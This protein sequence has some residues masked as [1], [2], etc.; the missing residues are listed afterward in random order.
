MPNHTANIL[1]VSG[2]DAGTLMRRHLRRARPSE[3][4]GEQES[5]PD[6]IDFQSIVP[7][8]ASLIETQSGSQTSNGLA[9]LRAR[10]SGDFTELDQMLS[11]PWVTAAGITTREGLLKHFEEKDPQAIEMGR[12]ALANI[13]EHGCPTWYEWAIKYW[14]TKWNAY[15]GSIHTERSP[16]WIALYFETAWSPP[17]P[18]LHVLAELYPDLRFLEICAD[19]GGGFIGAYA[20]FGFGE[21][22]EV[23][24]TSEWSSPT[25]NLILR[26]LGR[27][28]FRRRPKRSVKT[29]DC[30]AWQQIHMLD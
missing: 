21:T 19:E 1:I 26:K 5:E 13:K 29:P 3:D 6:C 20:V 7:M 24:E 12:Q 16:N 22:E 30:W 9:Y 23:P 8:P 28:S 4:P 27:A 11:W 18:V 2:P 17:D 10:E 15:S 14:G 25:G